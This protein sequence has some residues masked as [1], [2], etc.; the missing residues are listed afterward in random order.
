MESLPCE[1]GL[2]VVLGKQKEE[3]EM[4]GKL[5]VHVGEESFLVRGRQSPKEAMTSKQGKPP[6][7]MY[8]VPRYLANT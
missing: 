2:P 7:L 1:P 3:A 4:N 5:A 6:C 8:T